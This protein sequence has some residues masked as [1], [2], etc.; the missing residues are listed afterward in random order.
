[1]SSSSLSFDLAEGTVCESISHTRIYVF[2][3][4]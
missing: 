4:V 2:L 1:M 3:G